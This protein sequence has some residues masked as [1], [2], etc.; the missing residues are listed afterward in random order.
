MEDIDLQAGLRSL[1]DSVHRMQALLAWKQLK[2]QEAKPEQPPSF[3]M[4]DPTATEL[5]NEY[6]LFSLVRTHVRAVL[7]QSS[8]SVP[9]RLRTG[10]ERT[11]A[12]LERQAR[13]L[14]LSAGDW[15]A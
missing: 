15:G 8:H 13:Q 9:E 6:S 11:L 5:R 7:K 4:Y 10:I 12:E 2:Q 14:C 3:Q 1:E